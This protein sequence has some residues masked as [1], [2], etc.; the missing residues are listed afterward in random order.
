VPITSD[1]FSLDNQAY[2]PFDTYPSHINFGNLGEYWYDLTVDVADNW[3]V[4]VEAYY[5]TAIYPTSETDQGQVGMFRIIRSNGSDSST[6]LTVNF[7]VSG[8]ATRGE[9]YQLRI[10]GSSEPLSGDTV[11]IGAGSGSVAILVQAL[12]NPSWPTAGYPAPKDVILTLAAAPAGADR[13]HSYTSG[14]QSQA[15][16]SVQWVDNWEKVGDWTTDPNPRA[17]AGTDQ[18]T[19]EKL[20]WDITGSTA[21]AA[22]LGCWPGGV[23]AGMEI[24]IKPL[25]QI[26]E[27]RLR[28]NVAAATSGITNAKFGG[29]GANAKTVLEGKVVSNL[30]CNSNASFFREM[31]GC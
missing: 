22:E 21:D 26:L 10:D 18:D 25:L 20:A 24:P 1:V 3:S 7:T 2:A 12:W 6:D 4:G 28:A 30:K 15:K 9:H 11:T 23:T 16:A 19:L 29:S 8:T 14:P 17:R 13:Q 31:H 27:Q 5:D